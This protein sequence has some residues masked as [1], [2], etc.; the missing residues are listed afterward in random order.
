MATSSDKTQP[1]LVVEDDPSLQEALADTLEL[2]GYRALTA[3]NA[4]EAFL[5]LQKET[6]GLVLSDVHMPGMDGHGLLRTLKARYPGIPV[7][8][9]TAYGQITKA[10]EAM[11]DGAA[12]YLPK[13]FE[14]DRLVALIARHYRNHDEQ[15]DSGLVAEDANTRQAMDLALRVAASDTT[16]LLTGE[17]GVGKEVFARYIHRHSRRAKGPFIAVNCAA[18]PET[19]LESVLFGHEKGSF[20]G[21]TS[22]Q[23]GK[24]EQANGGILLLDEVS[25]MPLMLQV[26]LLRVLQEKEVER[27]GA[28][29]PIPLDV[30]ILATTN[31]DLEGWVG[32][33]R[34]R[35]DLFYRLNVF[36]IEIPPLRHRKEDILPLAKHLLQR[37]EPTI[38]KSGFSFS[39]KAIAALT[40]YGWP[41]NIRELGNVVQRAMILAPGLEIGPEHLLLPALKKAEQTADKTRTK[42]M[43]LKDV[44]R[45]TILD[46]LRRMDGSRRRTAEALNMSERTLRHK[47]K[48]YREAGFLD[49]DDLL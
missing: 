42:E 12:D 31:R 27:V 13:P 22:A 10:V 9:M 43:G 44:E 45:E 16:V 39:D 24:F 38:G 47:L 18:I 30:R 34:F 17:S 28:R 23:A 14:P 49:G 6:P 33:G 19:L 36:P 11:R 8:L 46:T 37:Y 26:K 3:G 20:T 15:D 21:A 2:S 40:G 5:I 25:E 1:I 7:V 4:E 29:A 35:E 48:Q 32:A 41:G